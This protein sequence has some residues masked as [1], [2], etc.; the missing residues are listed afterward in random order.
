[1]PSDRRTGTVFGYQGLLQRIGV[2]TGKTAGNLTDRQ[3]GAL[4]CP[5]RFLVPDMPAGALL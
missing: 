5:D 3:K 4:G 2:D 1:M